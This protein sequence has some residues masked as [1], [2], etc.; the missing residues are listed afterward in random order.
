MKLLIFRDFIDRHLI[1]DKSWETQIKQNEAG[2]TRLK[3]GN[4]Q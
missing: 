1:T 2:K 4:G 3:I